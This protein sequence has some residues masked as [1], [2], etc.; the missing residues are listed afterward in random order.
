MGHF[1]ETLVGLI[2]VWIYELGN[3]VI[4]L[5]TNLQRLIPFYGKNGK[6]T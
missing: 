3:E 4:Y 6:F 5:V 1:P 2:E